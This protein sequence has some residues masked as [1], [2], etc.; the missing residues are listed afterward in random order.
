MKNYFKTS[1]GSV[2]PFRKDYIFI[3]EDEGLEVKANLGLVLEDGL[4]YI[5]HLYGDDLKRYLDEFEEW[6]NEERS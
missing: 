1:E 4:T 6:L 2:F 3:N 5:I